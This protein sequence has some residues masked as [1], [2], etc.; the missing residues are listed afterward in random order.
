MFDIATLIQDYSSNPVNNYEMKDFDISYQEGNPVCGDGINVF[1]KIE[2]NKI[3]EFSF[4]GDTSMIT[5]T[6][7]S[8]LAEEIQGIDLQEILAWDLDFMREELGMQVSS[9]RNRAV[10]LG[11]LATRNAIHKYINDGKIDDFDDLGLDD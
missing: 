3:K 10:L 2:N 7:V 5:T 8:L 9:R 1:L 4:T 11:L 6:A